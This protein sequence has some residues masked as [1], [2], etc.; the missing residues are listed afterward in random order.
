MGYGKKITFGEN[1][2]SPGPGTYK[3]SKEILKSNGVIMGL[4]REVINIYIRIFQ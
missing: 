2:V 1:I 3:V 4:G